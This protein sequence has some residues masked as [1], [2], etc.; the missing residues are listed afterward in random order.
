M[1]SGIDEL[2]PKLKKEE[3]RNHEEDYHKAKK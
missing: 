3:Q 2:A 1:W